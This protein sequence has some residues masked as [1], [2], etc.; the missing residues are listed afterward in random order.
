M[1]VTVGVY[2]NKAEFEGWVTAGNFTT[3]FPTDGGIPVTVDTRTSNVVAA[4]Y[5]TAPVQPVG[6][7][8]ET[9]LDFDLEDDGDDV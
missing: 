6:A 5:P 4:A 3:F 8:L 2:E 1:Q 9:T 7:S